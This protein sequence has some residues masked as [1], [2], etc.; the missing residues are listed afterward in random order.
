MQSHRREH[1]KS[2][3]PSAPGVTVRDLS[4]HEDYGQCVALQRATWGDDFRELVPPAMLMIA[5]KMGGIAIGGFAPDGSL[6][7]FVFGLTGLRQG[8]LTHW[9]HMLA[10]REDRRDTG[11]GRTLK[12]AQRNRVAALGVRRVQW[13][14]DPLVARN[15]HLNVTLLGTRVIEY[16][17]DMYGENPMSR[18]DSIIG[19]DRLVVNWPVDA[20]PVSTSPPR[21][22]DAPLLVPFSDGTTRT[23]PTDP[24]VR[25]GIP[26]DIQD[27]KRRQP[28]D[29]RHWRAVTREWFTHYFARGYE[30]RGFASGPG[31][32]GGTY[33][34]ERDD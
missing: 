7:G 31:T 14:F 33:L 3:T 10:V 27:L 24:M 13:S 8:E 20:P 29:A 30:V 25:I 2:E 26:P 19:S 34:L 5:Q 28:E 11:I 4:T 17:E 23:P 21:A 22:D 32:L 16:V 1:R 18:T 6:S 12:L 15:A 9:S